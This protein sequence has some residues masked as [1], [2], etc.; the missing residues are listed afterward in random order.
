MA[1]AHYEMRPFQSGWDSS[2]VRKRVAVSSGA[3][4]IDLGR[5]VRNVVFWLDSG[6]SDIHV[7]WRAVGDTTSAATTD[8]KYDDN[9][10]RTS[11]VFRSPIDT[12][13]YYGLGSTG[14]INVEAW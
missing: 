7:L 11:P 6:S 2:Y 10:G 9:M 3:Q 14:Y 8:P 13:C 12:F 5:E 1:S 4:T